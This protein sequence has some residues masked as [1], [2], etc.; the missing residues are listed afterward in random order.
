MTEP[1]LDGHMWW[2]A[3]RA[4]GV[5]AL[6]LLTASVLLGLA[7][8][9]RL[10][11]RP[12]LR[13][14]LNAVHQHT[15]IAGLVAIAVHGIT[16]LGDGWLRPGPAGITVPFAISYRPAWTAAGIVG[17]YLAALLGLTFWLRRYIGAQL[18]RRAHRLTVVAYAL[19]LV[20]V[21][22][23]GTDAAST[24]LRW[25][26]LLSA[27]AVATLFSLRVTAER[28]PV[29]SVPPLAAATSADRRA[30]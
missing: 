23:A 28:S 14:W 2:L 12:G 10:A 29:R 3:S 30:A 8:A 25:P 7:M 15:A 21:L 24:W 9:G 17:G 1:T 27:L 5:V 26:M 18:W 19:S 13:V 20:H 22:G 16:L 4:S 11:R 6:T